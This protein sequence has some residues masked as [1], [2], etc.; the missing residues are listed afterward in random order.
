MCGIAGHAGPITDRRLERMLDLLEHRGPDS[1]GEAEW[2]EVAAI[3]ATRLAIRD[4]SFLGD[5]PAS[6]CSDTVQVV[7]NGE[8]Y[9]DVE[10]RSQLASRGHIFRGASDTEVVAH[11][12]EEWGSGAWARFQGM[13]AT[14]VLDQERSLLLLARDIVG[15]KPLY[16]SV[17]AGNLYFA[18]ESWVVARIAGRREIDPTSLASFAKFGSV[19]GERTMFDGILSLEPGTVRAWDLRSSG[20]CS[21]HEFLPDSAVPAGADV[22]S[23]NLQEGVHAALLRSSRADVPGALLLS[24]G[25][26]SGLLA[27][28]L[29]HTDVV[30]EAFTL[31]FPHQGYDELEATRATALHYGL[32]LTVVQPSD[33][34]KSLLG[35]LDRIDQPTV[36]GVNV[37]T[38][39]QHVA[40][41]GFKL[42]FSGLGSDELFGGYST[43][44]YMGLPQLPGVVFRSLDRYVADRYDSRAKKA[45]IGATVRHRGLSQTYDEL[46]SL[47]PLLWTACGSRELSPPWPPTRALSADKGRAIVNLEVRRYLIDT[48]LRDADVASMRNGVELRAPFLHP[49]MLRLAAAVGP[50]K[51]KASLR[52]AFGDRLPQHL[53]RADKKK[54]FAVP[55]GAWMSSASGRRTMADLLS[56]VPLEDAGYVVPGTGR[57]LTER[58]AR[59]DLNRTGSYSTYLAIFAYAVLNRWYRRNIS[60]DT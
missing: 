1:R 26:D 39:T 44:R 58:M 18:S 5:Q 10:L 16:Y 7:L 55:L 40:A 23:R 38:I 49:D 32:P 6:G 45:W 46:R 20:F 60:A 3:G 28:I 2:A 13:F 56:D 59:G 14:A 24:G 17:S 36:D 22:T 57:Q 27:G 37:Y 52:A 47:E 4:T 29:S 30:T 41:S 31:H 12:Y 53:R 33:F 51:S 21:V 11:A 35:Y 48:L 34:E 43:F 42:A 50:S 15:E 19:R 9:N 54:G 8:I 25:L